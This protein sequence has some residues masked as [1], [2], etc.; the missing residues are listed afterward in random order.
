R[1]NAALFFTR[2]ITHFCAPV[3]IFLAGT[4]AFLAAARGM[5]KPEL[6]RF[7]LVR[8]LLLLV[9]EQTVVGFA[10]TFQFD[11]SFIVLNIL[12]AIG[13]SMIALAGL[14]LLPT[15][16]VGVVGLLLIAAHNLFDSVRPDDVGSLRELWMVLH[17][18]GVLKPPPGVL[19]F[20]MYPLIPWIGVMAA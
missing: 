5:S 15:W 2:W 11:L 3:F 9:L 13:W 8:G 10:L 20:V 16:A 6:A 17:V 7:L 14:V 18:P 19:V 1:T 12:W 4:G